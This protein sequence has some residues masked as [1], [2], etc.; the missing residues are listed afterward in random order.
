[1]QVIGYEIVFSRYLKYNLKL[2]TLGVDI[3]YVLSLA[4]SYMGDLYTYF[5]REHL[6][7]GN[8]IPLTHARKCISSSRMFQNK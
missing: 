6:W 4:D 8:V 2:Y 3:S 5:N 1:M 7:Y